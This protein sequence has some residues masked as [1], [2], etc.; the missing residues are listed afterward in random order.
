MRM[1][2]S[3]ALAVVLS[4][5]AACSPFQEYESGAR[6]ATTYATQKAI[7]GDPEK[8]AR[9]ET[10]AREVQAYASAETYLTVDLL[11]REITRRIDLDSLDTADKTLVT[12]LIAHLRQELIDRL[13]PGVL[14]ED[15]RLAVDTVST[16][17]IAAAQM[18]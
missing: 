10:I 11:I 17:V 7:N 14:P 16:W 6:L 4:L 5:T 15:L 8:A 13:G 1:L 2:L 3:L 12:T 9:V 18:T